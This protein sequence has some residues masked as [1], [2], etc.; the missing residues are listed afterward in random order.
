MSA[1]T[2]DVI[3]GPA[4][5]TPELDV[6]E[7]SRHRSDYV[8]RA[9]SRNC[10]AVKVTIRAM[11]GERKIENANVSLGEHVVPP[12]LVSGA[13]FK[14]VPGNIKN[15]LGRIAQVARQVPYSHGTPFV[16]GAYLI[17][18]AKN[19]AG[20]SPA[21][22]VFDKLNNL[23][24]EY[25]DKAE[26]L[27][28]A[29]ESHVQNI[30]NNFPLE[31]SSMQRW[32]IDGDCFVSQHTISTMLFPLGAGLPANFSEK[33]QNGFRALSNSEDLTL[34]HRQLIKSLIP[35]LQ[36]VV[37]EVA[38]DPGSAMTEDSTASWVIEAQQATSEAVAEAVK[39]MIQEPMTEFAEALSNVE[40]M[41]QRGSVLRSSTI[42]NLRTAYDKLSGF[43]F[44]AP[45]DLKS[46]LRSIGTVIN[47]VNPKDINSS[48]TAS[49]ELARHFANVR[50]DMTNQDTHAA[51]YG[52][53]M[54][55]LDL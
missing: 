44:L 28:E 34:E 38:I 2:L 5:N 3:T 15:P 36:D 26:E 18:I 29:W 54:R 20:I 19:R 37:E 42:E 46:R 32:L 52:Q 48:A 1:E 40:G 49:R 31:Y 35:R 50:E 53:F 13:R 22:T 9:I 51:V 27:K 39:G 24:T 23:R 16:G 55:G 30:R 25:R 12:E 14:L 11:S 41:L 45:E 21:Q 10:V 4:V 33:L 6:Q 17:P 8:L 43:S 7:L 47:G